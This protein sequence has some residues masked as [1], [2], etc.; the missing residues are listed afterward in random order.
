VSDLGVSP[1]RVLARLLVPAASSDPESPVP[2]ADEAWAALRSAAIS[3]RVVPALAGAVADGRL[4]ATAEQAE[5]A[6]DLWLEMM[7][8]C[9]R[10]EGRLL[11]LTDA[12]AQR[13]VELRV[14][15]GPASAHL[16]HARPEDRQ[17]GDLDVLV[18]GEDLPAVFAELEAD[19]FQRRF[20]E[21]RRG[22]D[23]R[24][25]KSVSFAGEVEID[26]H[27]TLAEGPVGHRIPVDDLWRRAAP[28]EVG[29]VEVNAL[30]HP[31]RFVH[32]CL[33]TISGRHRRACRRCPTWRGASWA[34]WSTSTRWPASPTGG[35]S[36][37]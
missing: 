12:L 9:L 25:T 26:V 21:P 20:P 36:V 2:V 37:R 24:F 15:K 34:T 10:I 31:E 18:R 14:L 33:H 8:R 23:Q 3:E 29:G 22:F 28:F 30:D 35:G 1:R 4:A 7:R 13:G 27:R 16:D 32:A 6:A 11:W 17:F 19:G 5:D